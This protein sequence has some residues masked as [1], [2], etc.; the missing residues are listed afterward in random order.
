[1]STVTRL[2]L[3]LIAVGALALAAF[4][5]GSGT[6][7]SH[8]DGAVVITP[9][10]GCA[11]ISGD[12]GVVETQGGMVNVDSRGKSG[13]A[14]ITCG[15]SGVPNETGV[16]MTFDHESTGYS[17]WVIDVGWTDDWRALLTPSG[18]ASLTCHIEL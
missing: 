1:M 13:A 10:F 5:M 3:T 11:L 16:L 2:A 6:Q 12:G 14:H 7:T 17:C 9:G 18:H 15:A 8:A 4:L